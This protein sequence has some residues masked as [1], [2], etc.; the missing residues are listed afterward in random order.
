MC[1][2]ARICAYMCMC[3]RT[4][5]GASCSGSGGGWCA[6]FFGSCRFAHLRA[7]VNGAGPGV[8]VGW[9]A[10]MATARPV[11]SS[12][13]CPIAGA[14][15]TDGA[16]LVEPQTRLRREAVSVGPRVV[17]DVGASAGV[18]AFGPATGVERRDIAIDATPGKGKEKRSCSRESEIFDVNE[19]T[20]LMRMRERA[21]GTQTSTPAVGTAT[22]VPCPTTMAETKRPGNGMTTATGIC[23]LFLKTGGR[24]TRT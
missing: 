14:R 7:A 12:A 9:F 21:R 8:V 23:S 17:C 22:A 24:R 13:H 11:R 3:V 5:R 6:S 16:T 4:W 18:V 15:A 19:H 10:R 1:V 2:R 20:V